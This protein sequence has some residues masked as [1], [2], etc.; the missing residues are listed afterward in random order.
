MLSTLALVTSAALELDVGSQ[1]S[2]EGLEPLERNWTVLGLQFRDRIGGELE[3]RLAQDELGW[4]PGAEPF[5]RDLGDIGQGDRMHHEH[6]L[7]ID[8][9]R[10]QSLDERMLRALH[11]FDG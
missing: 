1:R 8:P 3:L 6:V 9:D 4:H 7:A 10:L 2:H 5:G 11:L